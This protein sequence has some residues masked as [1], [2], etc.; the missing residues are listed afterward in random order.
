MFLVL[1]IFLFL[2]SFIIVKFSTKKANS[3]FDE[4]NVYRNK[5]INI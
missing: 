3:T 1:L 2:F 5:T 4:L